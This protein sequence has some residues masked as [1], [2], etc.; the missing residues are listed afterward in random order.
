MSNLKTQKLCIFGAE[1]PVG[2]NIIDILHNLKIDVTK[3]KGVSDKPKNISTKDTNATVKCIPFEDI[4]FEKEKIA[5]IVINIGKP[6]SNE[7]ISS[8]WSSGSSSD[9]PTP[10]NIK[11]IET[12]FCTGWAPVV[13]P[14]INQKDSSK[15]GIYGSPHPIS[16]AISIL[17]KTISVGDIEKIFITAFQSVSYYGDKAIGALFSEAKKCFMNGIASPEFFEH[18]IAFNCIPSSAIMEDDHY[19]H[20]EYRIKTE[21]KYLTEYTVNVNAVTMPVLFGDSFFINIVCSKPDLD[22]L[23]RQIRSD[24]N[25]YYLGPKGYMTP[26]SSHTEES[27]YVG[28]VRKLDDN[29]LSMWVSFD[30]AY[31]SAKNIVNI[32]ELI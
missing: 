20:D 25:F 22:A 24:K 28:R 13:V 8:I 17:L 27:I 32:L 7:H 11:I 14:S 5:D 9:D 15:D 31:L 2:R 4:N 16:I 23:E 21:I 1:E 29:T 6:L 30:G 12:E 10:S 19:S 26:F 3:I 18:Q